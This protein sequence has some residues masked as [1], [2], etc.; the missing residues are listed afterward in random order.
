MGGRKLIR[1]LRFMHAMSLTLE[2]GNSTFFLE[3]LKV[4]ARNN[5]EFPVALKA[6]NQD[7][8]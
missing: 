5:L 3:N 8:R 7:R 2:T 4:M 6:S 1:G